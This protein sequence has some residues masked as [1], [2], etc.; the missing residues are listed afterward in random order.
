MLGHPCNAPHYAQNMLAVQYG[1]VHAGLLMLCHPYHCAIHAVQ[2]LL[3]FPYLA[4]HAKLSILDEA[5][6]PSLLNCPCRVAHAGPYILGWPFILERACCSIYVLSLIVSKYSGLTMLGYLYNALY[7]GP[8]MLAIHSEPCM[9]GCHCR[10]IHAGVSM[11]F[12]PCG[13]NPLAIHAKLSMF[14]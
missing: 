11:L 3:G 6:W 1:S 14:G 2:I 8:N 4:I 5:C 13:A 12:H 7:A 9:P 10:A